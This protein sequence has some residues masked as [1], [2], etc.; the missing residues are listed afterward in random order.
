MNI[1]RSVFAPVMVALV[2]LVT[3]GWFLQQGVTQG[4]NVYQQ[5]RLFE[6]VLSHIADRYVDSTER[7]SLYRM[8][9]DGLIKELGDPHTS[10]MTREDHEKLRV[11]TQGEYGGLGIQIDVRDGW[12][13]VIAPLPNTPAERAGMVSGDRIV[14]VNGVSTQGWSSDDAVNTLRGPKGQPVDLKVGRIGVD[15]LIPFTIVRDEIHVSPVSTAYVTEDGIGYVELTVFSENAA[16]TLRQAV[17]DLQ[18][19]G[20]RGLVLDLRR[21][22]G[23]LLDQGVA[24]SDLFLNRGQLILETRSRI[25]TQNQKFS[26]ISRDQFE[27]LPVVVLLG[28]GSASASEIVAG[29]LQDHD[30]ALVIGETSFGKGSVQTLFPLSGENFLK[31]TTARWYTPVGR[32]IQKPTRPGAGDPMHAAAGGAALDDDVPTVSAARGA[33]AATNAAPPREA[34]QTDGGRVVYGGGGIHPDIVI[35]P[36]TLTATEI[37][38]GNAVQRYGAKYNDVLFNYAVRYAQAHTDLRQGFQIPESALSEFYQELRAAGVEVDRT[39]YDGARRWV[40]QG[41]AYR[42]SY[43]K[44]GEREARRRANIEDS[45]VQLANELL[46]QA[47]SPASLFNIADSRAAIPAGNALDA[48]AV[49]NAAPRP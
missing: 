40:E 11:Q 17:Q 1:R 4:G 20:L 26:A 2:A 31:L 43:S 29:A 13:T 49:S 14:E 9:I 22:P 47:T 39:T 27:G 34:F 28:P 24:V 45:Q 10:F 3:G 37:D 41:L 42:I 5:A 15:E 36:D 21:N 46:R 16:D 38:F 30:R 6:D 7:N 33:A 19:Q 32:S 12:V 8:A 25:A 18:R 35:A 44:W 23:G 48:A